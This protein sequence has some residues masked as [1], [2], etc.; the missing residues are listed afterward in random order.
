VARPVP[1]EP[2]SQ[3][4]ISPGLR[5]SPNPSFGAVRIE[6]D[7]ARTVEILDVTGRR[8]VRAELAPGR[9]WTWDGRDDGGDAT[10][11]GL[12]FVRAV[13]ERGAMSVLRIVRLDSHAN[14]P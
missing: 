2:A 7:V 9:A 10:P 12:Y 13:E 6:S 5:L 4:E 3:V 8:I 11:A 1:A 14:A